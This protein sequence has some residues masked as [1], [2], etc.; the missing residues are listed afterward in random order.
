MEQT[1][2]YDFDYAEIVGCSSVNEGGTSDTFPP[3][4]L[5]EIP[6]LEM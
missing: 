6:L 4:P 1:E 3:L 2:G 5:I